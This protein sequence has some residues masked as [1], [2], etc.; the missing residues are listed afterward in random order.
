M[1]G[2]RD[3]TAGSGSGAGKDELVACHGMGS[4][5]PGSSCP[6]RLS[7]FGFIRLCRGSR[8]PPV[9]ERSIVP[10]PQVS[11]N[12]LMKTNDSIIPAGAIRSVARLQNRPRTA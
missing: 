6:Q 3:P 11:V 4:P 12:L 5:P 9:P 8:Q 7:N 10:D 1:G 2:T